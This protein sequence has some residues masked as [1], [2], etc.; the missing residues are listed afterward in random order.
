LSAAGEQSGKQ[1]ANPGDIHGLNLHLL[2]CVRKHPA[3]SD[4]YR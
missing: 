3:D 1:Q 2:T 4:G